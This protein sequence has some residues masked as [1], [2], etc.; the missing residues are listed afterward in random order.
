MRLAVPELLCPAGSPEAAR[1]AL[2]AGADALYLGAAAFGARA[3]A[4]FDEESLRQVTDLCHFLGRRVHVTVNTLVKQR[5]LDGLRATLDLLQRLRADAV[6]GQDMGV[7]QLIREEYPKLCVHASTQMAIHNVSGA[8]MLQRLG[9]RRVVLARECTLDTIREVAATG[10]ETEVFIHGAQCVCVSGQCRYSGLIGGRSGNRG[11][12]AQPCRLPYTWQGRTGAWLSPR[13]LCLR[14]H[15]QALAQAGAASFKI[16]GR[17]KRPEYVYV[18]T[19]AYRQAL[20]A[21]EAGR[22]APACRQEKEQLSQMFSRR[23][24]T[25]YAF[26]DRDADI[27]NPERVSSDGMPLGRITGIRQKGDVWLAQIRADRALHNG[28]GLQ[29]RG[30]RDLDTIYSGPEVPAGGTAVLR[31]R[32]SADIGDTIAR[33][34]DEAL[35]AAARQHSTPENLPRVPFHAALTAWPGSPAKLRVWD[36]RAETEVT[37]DTVQPAQGAPLDEARA[38]RALEKTGD[39][40]YTLQ[41]LTLAGE[42]GYLSAAALNDMRRRA[43]EQLREARVDSWPLPQVQYRPLAKAAGMPRARLLYTQFT[44]PAMA[45]ELRA[46]GADRL[47]WAPQDITEAGLAKGLKQLPPDTEILL[48][49]QTTDRELQRLRDTGRRL[50][51]GSVGQLDGSPMD[52]GEGVPCWNRRAADLLRDLGGRRQIL[53]REL[54]LKEIRELTGADPYGDYILPVYGRAR[55]MWLNHCPARTAMG[56]A[57]ERKDCRLCEQGRGC[58]G[59]SLTDRRGEEFPLMPLRCDAG[60]LV[61]LLSCQVRSLNDRAEAELSWLLDFTLEDAQTAA[62][63]TE[64]YRAMM[65]G[66]PAF[67][68][69]TPERIDAGVE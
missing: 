46:A 50:W 57:G 7:L 34:D 54:S 39:T 58:L 32:Q 66:T 29:V 27:I 59:Q 21:L 30:R 53:P 33:I 20:D 37:G 68:P 56:L 14:D 17:L 3:T 16:E 60:C 13:D 61:Q 9:V 15:L 6:L 35:L 10:I 42:G 55:L 45:E 65:D 8:R 25:G 28:D 36:D 26:G 19:R 38:R 22:F 48:P 67:V 63:V 44:D 62:K 52:M 2:C 31:L 69:G 64:A 43:L 47:I 18:I 1:A 40:L 5:E 41:D 23:F 51:A 24:F 4:G 49:V 11:R 12:C